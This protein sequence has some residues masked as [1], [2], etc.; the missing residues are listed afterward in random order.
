LLACE[1]VCP[2]LPKIAEPL[3]ECGHRRGGRALL[4]APRVRLA[5]IQIAAEDDLEA[6]TLA[7]LPPLRSNS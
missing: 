4:P 3:P 5:Q 7:E 1:R 6:V 2:I